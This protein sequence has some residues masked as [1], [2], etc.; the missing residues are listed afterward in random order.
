RADPTLT[1]VL[2]VAEH[3]EFR[4]AYALRIGDDGRVSRH[5]ASSTAD[6]GRGVYFPDALLWV[7]RGA[8]LENALHQSRGWLVDLEGGCVAGLVHE[9]YGDVDHPWQVPF[10]EEWLRRRGFDEARTPYDD[11]Q[12][13]G[14]SAVTPLARSSGAE[15]R[16]LITTV[17]FGVD[18]RPL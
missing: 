5:P 1:A 6:D 18:R 17:P 15:R 7:I 4:P 8:G 14:P 16:V 11:R 13:D 9:G 3:D 12:T 2:T 10:V